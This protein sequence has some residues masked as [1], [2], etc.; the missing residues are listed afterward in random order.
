VLTT[1][2]RHVRMKVLITIIFLLGSSSFI[3]CQNEKLISVTGVIT[4]SNTNDPLCYSNIYNHNKRTG[5]VSDLL[6][7][8]RIKVTS[9]D[10]LQVSFLGYH[11][12]VVFIKT[13][14][15]LNIALKPKSILLGEVTIFPNQ[16]YLY[17]ILNKVR[18]KY[19]WENAI[20]K[21]SDL[22]TA[23]TYY[24]LETF[25]GFDRIELIE[26]YYNG[27][28]RNYDLEK[29]SIKQGR[30]GLKPINGSVFISSETSKAFYKHK[31]FH[32]SD[33][34]PDNPFQLNKR[35]LMLKYDLELTN[36]FYEDGQRIF[37]IGFKPKSQTQNYFSGI[38][39]I[40][41]SANYINKIT[42]ISKSTG[43]TPFKPFGEI[44]SINNARI[45]ISKSYKLI[46]N[47]PYVQSINFNYSLQCVNQSDEK[48]VY[49]SKAFIEAYAYDKVFTLP[50][51]EFSESVHQDFRD[52]T[53]IPYDSIF[54]N[55]Q[56]GFGIYTD[57][58]EKIS[59]IEQNRLKH[60][61]DRLSLYQGKRN[62]FQSIYIPWN[63]K[64][65]RVYSP[66]IKL[67]LDLNS[68]NDSSY[69]TVQSLL[70]P[71]GAHNENEMTVSYKIFINMCF[72]LMEIEKR[73]FQEKVNSGITENIN[74]M[75]T[76]Y[77]EHIENYRAT[78]SRF[79]KEVRLGTNYYNMI[80]W[81]NYI[82][83]KLGVDNF[84]YFGIQLDQF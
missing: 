64:R 15:E 77:E 58:N 23:K 75:K 11:D 16:N 73:E 83:R 6:G 10:S 72:D 31:L 28:Y 26:A 74:N 38:V 9:G 40:N 5:T 39:W 44:K 20:A 76:L 61:S 2:V 67:F 37:E 65:L 48:K 46:D 55:K 56:K 32:S 8:F 13:L 27:S 22:K 4:D 1:D 24:Q 36:T 52:I 84:K 62:I 51:F 50:L 30:L 60:N 14:G 3:L 7:K 78:I 12:T 33:N 43:K 81:N 80:V 18:K 71:S 35:N 29:L 69:I 47:K 54:W 49:R 21:R 70:D 45:S 41:I 19:I 34:F 79:K 42:L 53:A 82:L 66:N 59:F 68:V 25:N 57:E 63:I 17:D